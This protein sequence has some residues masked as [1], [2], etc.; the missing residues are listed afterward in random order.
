MQAWSSRRRR[1]RRRARAVGKSRSAS[2]V[3]EV[4]ELLGAPA[5]TRL[6]GPGGRCRSTCATRT[7]TSSCV[8]KPA[9]LVVHPGA[10]HRARHARAR[11]AARATPRS[12]TVGDP[13][14]ARASS[15]AST[16]TR[17]A[18]WSSPARPPP[19]RASSTRSARARRRPAVPR[20]GLGA[21]RRRPGGSSTRRSAGRSGGATR[22]AVRDG[23]REARTGYDVR[24]GLRRA[25]REPARVPRSRPAAP[26]RSASTSQAI[27][28]P[29]VGDAV[30]RRPAGRRRP[31]PPVPPRLPAASARSA[32]TSVRR[33]EPLA[34]RREPGCAEAE[35]RG[36]RT[37][38]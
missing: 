38:A 11:P 18:C 37:R 33:G 21:P 36:R 30:V 12:P 22:M 5:R 19:T 34:L 27:G 6:P 2:R 35:R 28:H 4:V 25:G 9:G 8:A 24:A 3:G 31:R 32:T 7:P 20:A 29:V 16:A 13:R 15:T 14:S 1:A 26:T 23:G 17:A 10:G